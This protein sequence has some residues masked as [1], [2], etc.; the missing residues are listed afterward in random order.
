[1]VK[2]KKLWL[3][4]LIFC[5][6]FSLNGIGHSQEPTS[7]VFVFLSAKNS[8][9]EYLRWIYLD[10]PDDVSQVE[11]PFGS[12]FATSPTGT[13]VAIVN[14]DMQVTIMRFEDKIKVVLPIHTPLR[15]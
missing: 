13:H 2:M 4:A 5:L 6:L 1:M 12:F 3:V 11:V 9:I 7:D 10:S 8:E 15:D 14:L